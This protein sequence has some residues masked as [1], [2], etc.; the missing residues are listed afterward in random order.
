M[1]TNLH[2]DPALVDAARSAG[3]HRT[4]REAV[5]AALRE[6]LRRRGQLDALSAFGTFVFEPPARFDYKA[7]RRAR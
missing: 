1:A 3:H 7:A 2:L 6:Y 4:K 5:E